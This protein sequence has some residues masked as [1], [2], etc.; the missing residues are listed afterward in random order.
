MWRLDQVSRRYNCRPSELFGI[1]TPYEAFCFDQAI[2]VF[3]QWVE[4][5]LE[6]IPLKKGKNAGEKRQR[7]QNQLFRQLLQIP[8]DTSKPKFRDPAMMLKK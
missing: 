7:A 6:E 4:Q 2:A 8:E 1:E 3:S 5:K